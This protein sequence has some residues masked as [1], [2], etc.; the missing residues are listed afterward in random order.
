MNL[1]DLQKTNE[2]VVNTEELENGYETVLKNLR[3][4]LISLYGQEVL[5]HIGQKNQKI[6]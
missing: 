6:S 4:K 2:N 5:S 1:T 3:E